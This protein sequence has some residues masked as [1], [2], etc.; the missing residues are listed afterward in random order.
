MS[1]PTQL[2]FIWAQTTY[3]AM[4]TDTLLGNQLR[5]KIRKWYKQDLWTE[6]MVYNAV[7]KS[8]LTAEQ[9]NDI[10]TK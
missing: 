4:M 5:D 8:V 7:S 2:D 10:L 1:E 9:V 6:V 3:T